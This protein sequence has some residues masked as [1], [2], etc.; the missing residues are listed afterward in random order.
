MR[1]DV[2]GCLL[3][4]THKGPHTRMR[5]HTHTHTCIRTSTKK[6]TKQHVAQVVLELTDSSDFHYLS[7]PVGI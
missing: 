3:I 2:Q 1:D 4:S 6:K 5:A 7:F